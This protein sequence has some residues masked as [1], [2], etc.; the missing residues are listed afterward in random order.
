MGGGRDAV[1][2]RGVA[3]L[4]IEAETRVVNVQAGA[5]R[6]S[7]E[8]DSAASAAVLGEK[9]L[10]ALSDD[11]DELAQ[12]LQALAGPAAG[13]N[14]G[15]IHLYIEGF[16]DG[17]LPPKSSIR[18]VRINSNPYSTEHD[19]RGFGRIE[20]FTKPGSDALRGHAFLHYNN[21]R[22]NSR[23]PLFEQRTLPPDM[24]RFF[25]FSLTGTVKK[26]RAS[27]GL[28][29]ERRSTDESA[30]L[31]A[32]ALDANLNPLAVNTALATPQTRTNFSPRLDMALISNHT[33]GSRYQQGS[34]R[35]E[36]EG[37]GGFSLAERAYNARGADRWA[38]VTET[39]VLGARAVNESRFQRIRAERWNESATDEPALIMQG[40]LERSRAQMG[41]SGAASTRLGWT[42]TT[43]MTHGTHTWKFGARLRW[44]GIEDTS[45][46]NF[47]GTCK[48]FGGAGPALDANLQP[49]MGILEQQKA[50]ERYRRTLL[51]AQF[52]CS[53]AVIRVLG[54]ASQ[55]SQAAGRAPGGRR[56]GRAADGR[57]VH[58]QPPR[59]SA[60]ATDILMEGAGGLQNLTKAM[61]PNFEDS[62]SGR[63]GVRPMKRMICLTA[64]LLATAALGV[65]Q[66]RGGSG[67]AQPDPAR[68]V[69]A[70]VAMLAQALNL[71]DAQKTQ[72]MKIFTD[73]QAASERYREEIQVVRQEMQTAIK[74]NDPASIDRYARD[75]GTATA[76]I[77]AIDAR[78]QAAFYGLLTADQKTKYD[79]M[80]GRGFGMGP[81][82]MGP[83]SRVRPGQ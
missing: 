44:S 59:G 79:Q 52:G 4:T 26:N 11:P 49:V 65:A 20:I 68:M 35:N 48:F 62:R 23:S 18:G 5:A 40:A 46:N 2:A 31:Y 50:L 57:G 77:T 55:F 32:T 21:E 60:T 72:A 63:R 28:D 16:S 29:F 38:Q 71:T 1:G 22:L 69:E 25:G 19:R 67:G 14:G 76:E 9:E 34:T 58:A 3:A 81:G 30:F 10:A 27:F 37:V 80:P 39:A 75:I 43:T 78:A 83:G 56:G 24:A 17:N 8:P 74:A 73:A 6:V 47:G 33:L 70:R 45:V 61:Q 51:F 53:A 36:N 82:G 12:Q 7:T 13:P 64:A 41:H 54:G 42:K 15:Q 66:M